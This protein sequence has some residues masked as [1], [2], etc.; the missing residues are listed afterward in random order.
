[1]SLSDL[2]SREAL[3][4]AIAEYDTLGQDHFLAQYGFGATRG[5]WLVSRRSAVQLQADRRSCP[6]IPVSPAGRRTRRSA[7]DDRSSFCPELTMEPEQL[8]LLSTKVVKDLKDWTETVSARDGPT[9][10][11]LVVLCQAAEIIERATFDSTPPP[12]AL[13]RPTRIELGKNAAI[14]DLKR[15]LASARAPDSRA[16]DG[17]SARFCFRAPQASWLFHSP[18]RLSQH[19]WGDWSVL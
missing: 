3:L 18:S 10:E 9:D 4:A 1:M 5:Y 2:T 7:P 16:N 13:K 6:R 15:N 11:Q 17:R 8:L 14:G 19:E 12:Q